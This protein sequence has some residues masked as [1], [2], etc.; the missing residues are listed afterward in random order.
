MERTREA[1]LL[2]E[3]LCHEEDLLTV[4]VQWVLGQ[5]ILSE[6]AWEVVTW[7]EGNS[8][9]HWVIKVF[10]ALFSALQI[11]PFFKQWLMFVSGEN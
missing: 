10:G 9:Q 5:L 2:K 11:I 4:K 7:I 3:D 8:F 6:C 1:Y